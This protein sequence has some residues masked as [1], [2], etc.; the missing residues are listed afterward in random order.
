MK[1]F[2]LISTGLLAGCGGSVVGGAETAD[3]NRAGTSL[4][5][6]AGVG[7]LDDAA[8]PA[9]VDRCVTLT[10]DSFEVAAGAEVYMCQQF[11][12]PFGKDVDI[13]W[14]D[15]TAYPAARFFAFSMPPSTGRSLA[16]PLQTCLGQGLEFHPTAYMSQQR[17]RTVGYPQPDMGYPVPSANGLM[18]DVH[19]LNTSSTSA[20]PG[21]ASVT[22]C[23]AKPGVVTTRVGTLDLNQTT[24]N[25]PPTP[26]SN[27]ATVTKTWTAS[28][29][30]VPTSYFIYS[31]WSFMTP[32]TLDIRATTNGNVFYDDA[33]ATSPPPHLHSPPVAM[34]GTQSIQW[35][36]KI[37]NDTGASLSFGDSVLSNAWCE[38]IAG[39]YP[40]ADPQNPDVIFVGP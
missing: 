2:V 5:G 22:L 10:M 20:L 15:G 37:Y 7:P 38:Y 4:D 21:S 36:C 32:R 26:M 39:Y 19:Y 9:N 16:S 24:L 30:G 17:H 23:S 35:T 27:P 33:L 34:T 12:N 25:V 13:V 11:A 31:S 6:G 29:G 18:L 40:V 1:W 3:A 28:A 8:A 14:A